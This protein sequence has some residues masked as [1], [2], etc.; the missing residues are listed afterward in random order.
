MRQL[1]WII[2]TLALLGLAACAK[3]PHQK[4]DAAEFMVARAKA[5]Q[6]STY[7]PTEYESAQQALQSAHTA[8]NE[9]EYARAEQSLDFSLQH[10]RRAIS[11]TEETKARLEAEEETRRE[12]A[13]ARRLVEEQRA[14]QEVRKA[15]PK[16]PAPK[17]AAEPEPAPPTPAATYTVREGENLWII[18]NRAVVYHDG[19]LWPLLYQANRDQI[20]DPQQI[21]PGQ[22][23]NIRRD[24]T[25]AEKEEARIKARE[26][27][28]FPI[29]TAPEPH[30][31][32][33]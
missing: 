13:E 21:Y 10:S 8:M 5:I 32:Q 29:P 3:P 27:N 19:F 16:K 26:S 9:R 12:Q 33:P 2:C 14:N 15:A 22:V 30:R 4:M 20:K 6:A 11:L 7:A 18:S 28:I 24:L 25:E 23:L 1:H 17:P 31:E